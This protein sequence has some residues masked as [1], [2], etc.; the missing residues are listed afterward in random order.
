M[1]YIAALLLLLGAPAWA[2]RQG[3]TN[4][5]RELLRTELQWLEAYSKGD[6]DTIARLEADEFTITYAD[7]RTNTKQQDVESVRRSGPL[8]DLRFFT[9]N[10]TIRRYGNVAVLS[11]DFV[12]EGRYQGGTQK[13]QEYTVRQRYLD[14]W[15]KERGQWRVT[16]SQLTPI[17]PAP[18][19]K[20]VKP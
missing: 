6:A 8:P 12:T 11:G 17:A 15:V 2:Q 14:V 4:D 18:A 5:D 19:A 20:T 13:G 3:L 16:A 10:V 1:Q 7:G 9:E